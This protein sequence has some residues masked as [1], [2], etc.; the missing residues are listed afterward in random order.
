MGVSGAGLHGG[1][2]KSRAMEIPLRQRGPV[3]ALAPGP[4]PP[5]LQKMLD[6]GKAKLAEPFVGI[7]A[8]G[9]VEPGLFRLAK[10]GIPLDAVVDA[11]QAFLAGLDGPTREA[12][13]FPLESPEWRSWNNM[14]P[15][16]L[17][18]GAS[19]QR[20]DDAGRG[21]ALA[22][23]RATM[24]AAGFESARNVMKLNETVAEITGRFDEYGEWFYWLSIFGE[25]S[26]TEPW[27]W[28]LDGHHL[29]INALILG[30]QLVMTPAFLGS[31]PV[32]AQGGKYAGTR[33]FAEEEAAGL[34]VMRAL[35]AEQRERATLGIS[36]PQEALG[37]AFNDNLTLP[38]EGVR[39]ADMTAEGQQALLALVEI[40]VGHIRPGHA[41]I[42][43]SEVKDHLEDTWFAWVGPVDDVSAFYYRVHSP[44]VLIEFDHQFGIAYANDQPT[45]NHV[46]TCV[47]TPN[48]ND[49]GYDLLRQHYAE[50]DHSS[51]NSPHLRGLV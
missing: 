46:H 33:V 22:I 34:R 8:D 40:Y 38:Y 2:K 24:S 12:A 27:G 35:T 17:R 48:G 47:R 3:P 21:R 26:N 28:Q 25:P 31:E 36:F 20:L 11:A 30:D 23:V 37:G 15:F 4:L 1:Q 18:H 5:F 44:V 41:E 29:I 14:H 6:A 39:Y 49:Y 7:T 10:T 42:K 32:Y 43:L 50:H 45:R 51:P 16:F 13:H 9:K 19:L